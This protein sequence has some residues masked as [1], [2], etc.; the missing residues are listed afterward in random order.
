MSDALH[1]SS[2]LLDQIAACEGMRR[3]WKA[4]MWGHTF[5]TFSANALELRHHLKGYEDGNLA[6]L[7]SMTTK[8]LSDDQFQ[9]NISRSLHNFLAGAKSLVD[10]SR[11]FMN[12]VYADQPILVEYQKRIR[13]EMS[14]SGV[15]QFVHDLRNYTLHKGIPVVREQLE[16][17]PNEQPTFFVS[18]DLARM[19]TWGRWSPT[20]LD[21]IDSSPEHL[22]IIHFVE[23]YVDQVVS[24]YGWLTNRRRDVDRPAFTELAE[25]QRRLKQKRADAGVDR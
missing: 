1:S 12:E 18:L 5:Y 15:V 10:H 3:Y 11:N 4:K 2:T 25:L 21:F 8:R 17:R 7:R 24:F 20:A 16:I 9:A 22:R 6:M 14:G 23:P 19:R 13:Q